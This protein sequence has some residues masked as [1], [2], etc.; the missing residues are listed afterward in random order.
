MIAQ[1][2]LHLDGEEVEH[3]ALGPVLAFEHLD[4]DILG[5]LGLLL[6]HRCAVVTE[7]INKSEN[8]RSGKIL[9]IDFKLK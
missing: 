5:G 7:I 8:A 2:G 1:V 4:R 9:K 3:L 6:L